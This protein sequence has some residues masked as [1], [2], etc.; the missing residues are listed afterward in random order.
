MVKGTQ[1]MTKKQLKACIQQQQVQELECHAEQQEQ[2]EPLIVDE[3]LISICK[4]EFYEIDKS[5]AQWND[6]IKSTMPL[7]LDT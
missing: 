6:V 2:P 4:A 1:T 3:T 7:V 5:L